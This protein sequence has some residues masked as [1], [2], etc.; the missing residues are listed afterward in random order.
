MVAAAA[1]CLSVLLAAC[2]SESV[3]T[4]SA[5]TTSSSLAP[6]TYTFPDPVD[7]S[8]V[9][10][11]VD[12]D[13][14]LTIFVDQQAPNATDMGAGSSD[15]PL[16][17][18]G[19]ALAQAAEHRAA[20]SSVRVIVAPGTYRESLAIESIGES[21]PAL[22]VEA[23]VPG[24][25]VV[26]GADV[27]DGWSVDDG[28]LVHEWPFDWTD[29][30]ADV[31]PIVAHREVVFVNGG[32]LNQVL[33]ARDVVPGTFRVD[34][35]ADRIYVGTEAGIDTSN[36][37]IEVAVRPTLLTIGGAQ[38][39]VVRGFVFTG[40]ANL[41]DTTAVSIF[42]ATNIVFAHNTVV[43]N[44]WTGLGFGTSRSVTISDNV[45]NMN[46]GG[47]VGVFQ[48]D[49]FLFDGNETSFNNWRGATG[50]YTGWSIAGVKMVG[51]GN[52]IFRGHR[53]VGNLTR[54]FWLDY[55]VRSVLIEN[56]YW[57][58]NEHDGAFI[59]A[60]PGPVV[61]RGATICD[62][63]RYGLHTGNVIDLAVQDSIL[64][65]NRVADVW[66]GGN[67]E[68]REL[69]LDEGTLVVPIAENLSFVQN[70]VEGT[71]TL[72]G[73]HVGRSAWR[74]V[75]T[76]LISNDNSWHSEESADAFDIPGGSGIDFAKWQELTGQDSNSAYSEQSRQTVCEPPAKPGT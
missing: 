64:C 71:G 69:E 48:A 12:E 11:T 39:L 76:S 13:T 40:A 63:A 29:T 15:S 17:S 24:S 54:G 1:I 37:T 31:A 49:R 30:T 19:A 47:G 21:A 26:T 2:S 27:W 8:S 18:I 14:D 6:I 73:T 51:G 9:G 32:R 50:D 74:S 41:F 44:S 34:E 16:R 45:I 3:S 22:I 28:M 7:V 62:N 72:L 5:S 36:M 66:I 58:G 23:E 65:G 4:P 25:A 43:D 33:S 68:G 20:G 53:S 42:N 59:E 52:T 56:A 38:N 61:I 55:N 75:L 35:S 70:T 10:A 57:C 60:T 46:G 67:D